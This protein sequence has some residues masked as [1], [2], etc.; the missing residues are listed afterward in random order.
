MKFI[1]D[2]IGEKRQ[3]SNGS[4][5]ISAAKEAHGLP[6]DE[7]LSQSDAAP[8]VDVQRLDALVQ[9]LTLE[10]I[11]M[12]APEN[13]RASELQQNEIDD[14][15]DS[16]A[17]CLAEEECASCD[18]QENGMD[19]KR[20]ARWIAEPQYRTSDISEKAKNDMG[21]QTVSVSQAPLEQSVEPSESTPSALSE[22]HHNSGDMNQK[23][24]VASTELPHA[25][26]P[27]QPA[28]DAYRAVDVP[29]PAG[30][31]G[32]G[33]KG[34]VK[35]RLLGFNSSQDTDIDPI[36]GGAD[37]KPAAYTKFPLGWLIVVGGPGLGAAFTLFNGVSKIGRGKDQTVPLDFGDNSISRENHAAI[38]YDPAQKSFFI[39]HGGKANLVRRN[40]RP[41]LSTEEL[42]AGDAITI[43]ETI[44]RFVPL[45]GPEFTWEESEKQ[46][47][48][49]AAND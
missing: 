20:V 24:T 38:A 29:Q 23:K 6:F 8:E 39:G 12:P 11:E 35:T 16:L 33:N 25:T 2:I 40:D 44:L 34:R 10:D 49:H 30:G 14:F 3:M 9:D 46:D 13:S 15:S 32:T 17:D 1:R 42:L 43:G 47:S 26:R 41:V 22:A 4:N 31:R 37:A 7:L 19:E 48:P 27:P 5:D 36:A 28:L 18:E 21:E 45:C